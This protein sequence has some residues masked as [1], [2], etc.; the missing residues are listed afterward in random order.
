[1]DGK[2][3]EWMDEWVGGRWMDIDVWLVRWIDK[4][5]GELK[6]EVGKEMGR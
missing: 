2:V 6:G 3:S 4:R 1:M 5:V